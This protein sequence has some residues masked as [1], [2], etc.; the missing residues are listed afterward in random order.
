MNNE[1][2]ISIITNFIHTISIIFVLS[3]VRVFNAKVIFFLESKEACFNWGSFAILSLISFRYCRY[4]SS[5]FKA[6][7]D[8][9]LFRAFFSAS[10]F[11]FS[12]ATF[13]S[14]AAFI[15]SSSFFF[16]SAAAAS[17][18]ALIAAKA[19]LFFSSSANWRFISSCFFACNLRS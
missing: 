15:A 19:C 9:S 3:L 7:S 12:L 8:A 5:S 14:S 17:F 6:S 16:F 4:L 18:W 1:K 2:K 11:S 13:F 10:I